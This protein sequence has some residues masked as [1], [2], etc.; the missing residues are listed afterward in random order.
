MDGNAVGAHAGHQEDEVCR[1]RGGCSHPAP[2]RHPRQPP[3]R[4]RAVM[5]GLQ[6][7]EPGPQAQG[8]LL[9]PVSPRHLHIRGGRRGLCGAPGVGR[10]AA[11][12]PEPQEVSPRRPGEVRPARR[13]AAGLYSPLPLWLVRGLRPP[14]PAVPLRPQVLQCRGRLPHSQPDRADVHG[15]VFGIQPAAH[16]AGIQ[17]DVH[18]GRHLLPIRDKSGRRLP[19]GVT[20][21]DGFMLGV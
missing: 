3:V 19:R 11:A 20:L 14:V 15:A 1:L 18:R 2:G 5:E 6:H 17:E 13:A 4:V 16:P 12:R 8:P 21:D 10:Q 7:A 9:V